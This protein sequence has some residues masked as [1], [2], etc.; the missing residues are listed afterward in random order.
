MMRRHHLLGDRPSTLERVAHD[1]VGLHSSD[2]AT[3]FVSLGLRTGS[4]PP[5]IEEA[6][7]EQQALVRL[8]AMRRTLWVMTPAH[9]AMVQSAVTPAVAAA[10]RRRIAKGLAAAGLDE[11]A[12]AWLSRVMGAIEAVVDDQP[13][14]S[15]R[16][17]SD[18]VP[19]AS[20]R[21]RVGG[22]KWG[23]ELPVLSR[24]VSLLAMEGRI[25]RDRPAGSW[26]SSQYT[27][28]TSSLELDPSDRAS[29]RARLASDWLRSFGPATFDDIA[30]WFGWGVGKT[31]SAL[32]EVDHEIV[33]CEGIEMLAHSDDL[34]ATPEH[35]P[36]CVLL[37]SLDP[38]VM[39]WKRRDWILGEHGGRLFDRNGNAGPIV[40]IDGRAVGAW[41]QT[42]EGA[43]VAEVFED[44]GAEGS[45]LVEG[46]AAAL[47][48]WLDG[49]VV[50]PRFPSPASREM[51]DR[52]GTGGR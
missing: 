46:A 5:A 11:D 8:H 26:V 25:V 28:T 43:V 18:V 37:P 48:G 4:K 23:G 38:S 52:L 17:L 13:G 44:V 21:V 24:L 30:W 49:V 40:L 20:Q 19:G 47:E 45:S 9:A 35:A 3:V 12:D 16:Q 6:L 27:W 31:R 29:I 2:P 41:G 39:G 7:Y 50:R 15:T 34:E 22:P 32:S 51:A 33:L 10:E 14:I 1:L 42:P 36:A